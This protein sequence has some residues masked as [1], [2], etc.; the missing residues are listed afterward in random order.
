MHWLLL[1]LFLTTVTDEHRDADV[2]L[3]QPGDGNATQNATAPNGTQDDAMQNLTQP[4]TPVEN[5]AVPLQYQ[6]GFRL[7]AAALGLVLLTAA[8]VFVA[9]K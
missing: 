5:D 1:F 2:D 8:F 7:G 3:L 6:D 4:S 9:R